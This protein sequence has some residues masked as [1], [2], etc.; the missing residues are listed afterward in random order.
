MKE[1]VVA[2]IGFF[3]TVIAALIPALLEK[4]NANA[5]MST[6]KRI[7]PPV[8]AILGIVSVGAA[9]IASST[10][11]EAMETSYVS[12][13]AI[14]FSL[15]ICGISSVLYGYMAHTWSEPVGVYVGYCSGIASGVFLLWWMVSN[16]TDTFVGPIINNIKA[17]CTPNNAFTFLLFVG[18]V[19]SAM[20]LLKNL[21]IS[22]EE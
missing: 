9:Y 17:E 10:C 21:K 12:P 8:L 6:I 7:P 3:G 19:A 15:G 11:N 13:M 5:G 4:R 14:Y 20:L 1:I 16:W 18:L 2:L 22:K